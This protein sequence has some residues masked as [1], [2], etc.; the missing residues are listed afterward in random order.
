MLQDHWR[1]ETRDC[2]PDFLT[3]CTKRERK[4]QHTSH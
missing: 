4:P 1:N 3:Y 2:R